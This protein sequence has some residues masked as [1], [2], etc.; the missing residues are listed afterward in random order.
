M[1]T[2]LAA[3]PLL[4]VVIL[5]MGLKRGGAQAGLA[6]WLTALVVAALFFGADPQVLYWAQVQGVF[7]ALYVLYIIW[8]A[9]F[10]FRVTEAAG[11]LDAMR[12]ILQ[13]ATPERTLQVLLLSWGFAS[14]LQGVGGFGVP[15]AVVAPIL[16]SLGLAPLHAVVLP[17]LGHAWAISFGSLGA[18]YE[19]LTTATGLE[20]ALIGPPM[21]IALGFVCFVVGFI[22][23]HTA[24]DGSIK[25][26]GTIAW[27]LMAI[28]MSGVQ[29]LSVQAGV[30]NIA[31]MLGALAG[32]VTG[33]VWA[34]VIHRDTPPS[35]SRSPIPARTCRQ[36]LPYLLLIGVI[37]AA[38]LIPSVKHILNRYVVTVQVPALTLRNGTELAAGQTKPISVLGHPGALL[39]IVTLLTLLLARLQHA[40]PAG[41]GRQI[42]QKIWRSGIKSTLGITTMMAMAVTM[43]NTGM[44][45]VLSEGMARLAGQLFP[46]IAPLV[47]AVGAF[48]T[49]SNT[50]SNVL[51]GAFQLQ[52]AQ[53]L[54]LSIPLTLA[55]H[56]AGAAVGSVFAPA[57]VM[58]GCSTVGLTDRESEALR[59]TARYGLLIIL[60][61]GGLGLIISW[62]G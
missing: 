28:T 21:A 6:G 37:L 47:G 1:T 18:S 39:V 56:N 11:T 13:R 44:V 31:A 10:F 2:L 34:L 8:G 41:S 19:A 58:V 36:L 33:G 49:G 14:F 24:S 51:L 35:R 62:I 45:T 61:L 40:L 60:T 4:V 38:N 20:G 29:F 26:P 53:A 5:M 50:N 3:L 55:L 7:R 48:L 27:A 15:V 9:L 16:V 42:R 57:K 46:L 25:L 23:L 43:Q 54:G 22:I 32:L 59:S 30:M 52:I 17:S 12:Q